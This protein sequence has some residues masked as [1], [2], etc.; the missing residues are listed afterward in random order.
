MIG[1]I[2]N[3]KLH[4]ILAEVNTEGAQNQLPAIRLS[5]IWSDG[6]V[7]RLEQI[8]TRLEI[9]PRLFHLHHMWVDLRQR[10]PQN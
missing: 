7:S 4:D 9:L 2:Q 6:G 5:G 3:M 1:Y 10:T 8:L